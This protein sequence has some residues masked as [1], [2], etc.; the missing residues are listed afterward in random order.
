[1]H[2]WNRAGHAPRHAWG[3]AWVH[4]GHAGASNARN[5]PGKAGRGPSHAH[6][7]ARRGERTPPCRAS[8]TWP[9][10]G[11]SLGLAAWRG[12]NLQGDYGGAAQDD[13]PQHA[14]LLLLHR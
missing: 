11:S 8:H 1:M 6:G 10:S 13:E 12:L 7:G 9:G 3:H 2:P 5:G 14:P 4:R